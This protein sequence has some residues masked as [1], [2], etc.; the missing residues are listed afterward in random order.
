M[1]E[2]QLLHVSAVKYNFVATK[3]AGIF[4]I[5]SLSEKGRTYHSLYLLFLAG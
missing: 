4:E 1:Y 3:N 2:K 5:D